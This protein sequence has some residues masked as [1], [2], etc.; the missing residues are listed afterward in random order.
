MLSQSELKSSDHHSAAENDLVRR[1][2]VR[3]QEIM[4][5]R[6]KAMGVDC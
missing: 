4:I 3:S 2:T 1:E 6:A 5:V